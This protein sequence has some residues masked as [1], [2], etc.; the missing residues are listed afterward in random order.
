ML[1]DALLDLDGDG[2]LTTLAM[3]L[4]RDVLRRLVAETTLDPALPGVHIERD[5]GGLLDRLILDEQPHGRLTAWSGRLRD[6]LPTPPLML[7]GAS[8]SGRTA[9]ARAVVAAAGRPLVVV[10]VGRDAIEERLRIAR[11][12]ARWYGAGLLIRL[13]GASRTDLDWRALWNGLDGVSGPL[14]MALSEPDA[15]AASDAAPREPVVVEFTEPGEALR[16]R[17]WRAL[18]PRSESIEEDSLEALAARFRFNPGRIARA[19]RRATAEAELRPPGH[20]RLAADDLERACRAVGSASMGPLAEK[21]PLPYPREDLIVPDR[22]E[23]ELDLAI[24][25]VRHR[26][27]V[28]EEWGFDRRVPMGRGLTALFSGPPGTGKTMAAQVLARTLGL[29]LY[30]VDLSRVMSKYIG[31]TEERLRQLFDEAYAS[32]AILFFDEADALFGKRSEVKDA[33]DRYANVEIG[34]LLQRMESHDGVTLLATNRMRDLDEAFLRRF[35]FNIHFPMPSESDRLRIWKG[36]F[37]PQAERDANLDLQALARRFELSGGEIKN[38]VLAAA[39][40]AAAEGHPIGRAHLAQALR[41]EQAKNGRVVNDE[42]L[43]FLREG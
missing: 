18:M 1:R 15:A 2:P 22:I 20:R 29:D 30:R 39:Y 12:E 37:P 33:H 17:L 9:S 11:R 36:M 16:V 5:D 14:L 28:L 13:D 21:L 6:R 42:S 32:G 35:H 38:I 43:R 4:P 19:I 8:G 3:Q 40:L 31:E 25:W 41:R 23:S 24:A 34:Y 10:E 26:R 27:K 7:V